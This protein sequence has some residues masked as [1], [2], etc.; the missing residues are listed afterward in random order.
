[1][2]CRLDAP[3]ERALVCWP[4]DSSHHLATAIPPG[5]RADWPTWRARIQANG[6]SGGTV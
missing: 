3:T 2:K 5:R 1:M 4:D 6:W